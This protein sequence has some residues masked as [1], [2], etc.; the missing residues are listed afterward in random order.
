MIRNAFKNL[1]LECQESRVGI[2][3]RL[4]SLSMSK[5]HQGL[6]EPWRGRHGS[7]GCSPGKS[8]EAWLNSDSG[9]TQYLSGFLVP[10]W[11]FRGARAHS[12][13][14]ELGRCANPK[15]PQSHIKTIPCKSSGFPDDLYYTVLNSWKSSSCCSTVVAPWAVVLLLSLFNV[16]ERK[17]PRTLLLARSN[18]APM[19]LLTP[20]IPHSGASQLAGLSYYSL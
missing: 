14:T 7:E 15:R 4:T 18:P 19:Q 16:M 5:T 2:S 20:I 6:E 8:P 3:P 9:I 17:K 11:G 10:W 12:S 13:I 1:F